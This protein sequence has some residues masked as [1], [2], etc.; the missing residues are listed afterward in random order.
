MQFFGGAAYSHLRSPSAFRLQGWPAGVIA[1]QSRLWCSLR[2]CSRQLLRRSPIER[3]EVV[4]KVHDFSIRPMLRK[5][6]GN[7]WHCDRDCMDGGDA[8]T[9]GHVARPSSSRAVG[10]DPDVLRTN[11]APDCAAGNRLVSLRAQ[12]EIPAS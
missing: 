6:I 4:E 2:D 11:R 1:P 8:G 9:A 12:G 7:R 5:G 3:Q 10:E